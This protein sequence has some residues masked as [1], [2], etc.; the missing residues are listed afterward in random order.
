M[1]SLCPLILKEQKCDMVLTHVTKIGDQKF[2]HA[3]FLAS[4]HRGRRRAFITRGVLQIAIRHFTIYWDFALWIWRPD[5][6]PF[7]ASILSELEDEWNLW[8][9]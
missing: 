2:Y 6:D 5:G 3:R 8:Q 4:S 9:T 7:R 1:N